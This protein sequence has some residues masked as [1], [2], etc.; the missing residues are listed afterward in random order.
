[1]TAATIVGHSSANTGTAG[2]QVTLNLPWPTGIAAGDRAYM[3]GMNQ[4]N[5]SL[6]F[7]A[8]WDSGDSQQLFGAAGGRL[9]RKICTGAETGNTSFGSVTGS[10]LAGALVVV[11]GGV[12]VEALANDNAG[13]AIDVPQVTPTEDGEL[14]VCIAVVRHASVASPSVTP[15]TGYTELEDTATTNPT[16]TISGAWLGSDQLGAG[17]SGVITPSGLV[18]TSNA[19]GAGGVTWLFAFPAVAGGGGGGG[20]GVTPAPAGWDEVRLFAP[21]H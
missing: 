1:M 15:A 14:L 18:I 4:N 8:D 13:P 21:N 3:V 7:G 9:F 11:R 16:G 2:T 20:G 17:T 10:R 6:T 12:P 5:A 19:S